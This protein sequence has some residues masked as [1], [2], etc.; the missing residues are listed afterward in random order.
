MASKIPEFDAARPRGGTAEFDA[1][2]ENEDSE[3]GGIG[4]G[5][6]FVET[7]ISGISGG[8]SGGVGDDEVEEDE[9]ESDFGGVGEGVP[10]KRLSS[11]SGKGKEKVKGK[12][13][14]GERV[15]GGHDDDEAGEDGLVVR[16]SQDGGSPT[17]FRKLRNRE[18]EGRGLNTTTGRKS[19]SKRK[20][21]GRNRGMGSEEEGEAEEHGEG[22]AGGGKGGIFYSKEEEQKVV[23]KMDKWLVGFLAG[24][25]MLSFLD[26]SSEFLIP[27]DFLG[28]GELRVIGGFCGWFFRDRECVVYIGIWVLTDVVGFV[29]HRYW[30]C[31]PKFYYIICKNQCFMII[32]PILLRCFITRLRKYVSTLD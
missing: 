18:R 12:G 31:E 32:H 8:A 11:K 1:R 19:R 22:E 27:R 15:D 9:E 21:K 30:K 5:E 13:R 23:R 3:D 6:A 25:Y 28:A 16:W 24:L 14:K 29:Y 26:R 2:V 7:P 10:L 17:S 4:L 20:L